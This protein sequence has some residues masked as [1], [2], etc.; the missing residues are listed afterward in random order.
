[1]IK[2]TFLTAIH[3]SVNY[4]NGSMD[5]DNQQ[6]REH[7]F[8]GQIK[9]P[10]DL[11]LHAPIP[12]YPPSTL[13]INVGDLENSLPDLPIQ[14]TLVLSNESSAIE[15]S[16][17]HDSTTFFQDN[18][19][20]P[21]LSV[22]STL[23]INI[24]DLEHPLPNLP[25]QPTLAHFTESSAMEMYGP[26]NSTTCGQDDLPIPPLSVTS[27]LDVGD[28]GYPLPDLSIPPTLAL[29]DESD[30]VGKSGLNDSSNFCQDNLSN[31]ALSIANLPTQ[32]TL[33]LF[34]ESSAIEM[35]G[36]H[37]S[38]TYGQDDLPIL[39][40]S[41]AS[42][43]DV[44]DLG[45]P[46]PDLSIP[47]TLALSDESDPVGKSGP[48]DSSNF[49]QDNLSNP[50]LSIANLPTQ[51]T[52]PHFTE[53]SAIE[54]YGPH[55]STTYG[56]DDLPIPP[57]SVASFLDVGDL[58]YP[59]PDLS[60]PPTLALSDESGPVGKSGLNDSSNFCQDNLSNPALSIANLPTQ[61]TL[62]HFTKSSA[63]EMYGP[64]NSTTCGQDDLPIL[65]LSVTSF[66]D[67]GDLG[68]P[69][70]DLSIPPTLALSDESDP[71]GNS[72]PNDSSNFCRDN[73]SNPALSIE[74]PV[75]QAITRHETN[76]H[77]LESLEQYILF[78]HAQMSYI[79]AQPV[80]ID[81]F[82]TNIGLRTRS[83]RTLLVYMENVMAEVS[84]QVQ[85][86]EQRFRALQNLS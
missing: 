40:L 1:M 10:Q 73:L 32:P 2:T 65:P 54:M 50:A 42:F 24:G 74:P 72:G 53:S 82:S 8:G 51:P 56:Q 62:P 83:I 13:S 19:P 48:N 26:H 22:E 44:G 23:S 9:Q 60:I 35:Y 5:P 15:M 17:P 31:P 68:Y 75:S 78:L 49:C 34:T 11:P 63:I 28:L 20:V 52:L 21:A 43:L 79:G 69:L 37:N 3:A 67:V 55:N 80:P 33:A 76:K 25:T 16:G 85:T 7:S 61:P 39:P 81:R 38:T 59:L 36:P 29:S 84:N 12:R 70:P 27:F 4:L 86:Q 71:V 6:A 64:H 45:Y 77:Y 41:V 30:P 66:L 46:L 58:G 57:L 18:L 47:P 14:P